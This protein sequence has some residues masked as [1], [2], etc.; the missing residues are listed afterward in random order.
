MKP[1]YE[2]QDLEVLH[3]YLN[4]ALDYMKNLDKDSPRREEAI[5]RFIKLLDYFMKRTAPVGGFGILVDT[6]HEA[7]GI[8]F[9][10]DQLVK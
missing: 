8:I 9:D 2:D 10:N 3:A 4:K 1:P 7:Y 6:K 5:E